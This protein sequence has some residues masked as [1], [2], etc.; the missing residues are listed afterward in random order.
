MH[1]QVLWRFGEPP[2]ET[3][4]LVAVYI[5]V[6]LSLAIKVALGAWWQR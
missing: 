2:G 1:L 4:E 5:T 6:M 3:L